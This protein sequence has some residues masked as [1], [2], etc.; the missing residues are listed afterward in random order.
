MLL[1]LEVSVIPLVTLVTVTEL[2]I[3]SDGSVAV[4]EQVTVKLM[5]LPVGI[6]G[7]DTVPACRLAMVR[8]AGHVAPPEAVQVPI[9]VF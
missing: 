4:T 7:I 5:L 3:D 9:D 2:V 1:L 8:L 6:V